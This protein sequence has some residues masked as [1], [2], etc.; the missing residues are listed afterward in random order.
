VAQRPIV[1]WVVDVALSPH[2]PTRAAAWMGAM[3][4]ENPEQYTKHS[5]LFFAQ[6]FK[7]PT[8]VIAGERDPESEEL[9]FAL[10][11]RKVESELVRM[12]GPGTAGQATPSQVLLELQ[13]TIGWLGR[14]GPVP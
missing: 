2:G 8:L 5:P 13:A 14:F 6:S 3:P 10:Q 9:Y 12:R 11:A 1:D 4:W 7:T